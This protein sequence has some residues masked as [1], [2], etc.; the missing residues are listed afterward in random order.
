V[1]ERLV[2][3]ALSETGLHIWHRHGIRLENAIPLAA[4]RRHADPAVARFL[5][6][7]WP[8]LQRQLRNRRRRYRALKLR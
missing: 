5:T 8:Q 3:A 4:L 2:T 1:G 6:V 7:R